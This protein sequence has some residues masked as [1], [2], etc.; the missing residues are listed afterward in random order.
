[1][2]SAARVL[3]KQDPVIRLALFIGTVVPSGARYTLG[4]VNHPLIPVDRELLAGVGPLDL[5]LPVG[6]AA[7]W[8]D[9]VDAVIDLAVCEQLGRHIGGIDKMLHWQQAFFAQGAMNVLR[10]H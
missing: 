9:Q 8:A 10:A 6:I 3:W 2:T 1:M 4:T 7:R 5:V